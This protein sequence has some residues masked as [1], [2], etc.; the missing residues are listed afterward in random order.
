MLLDICY[1]L[2][3]TTSVCFGIS[4]C[5]YYFNRRLFNRLA[6]TLGWKSATIY[7]RVSTIMETYTKK[8]IQKLEDT[9]KKTEGDKSEEKNII[10]YN[11]KTQETTKSISMPLQ[12][13]LVFIKKKIDD[14]IYCK[15]IKESKNLHSFPFN[16]IKKPFI[17]VEIAYDDKKMEI[18]EHL[19]HFYL[20][21]NILLDSLFIQWYMKFWFNEDISDEYTLHIIDSNVQF[22]QL[23][24]TQS[25]LLTADGYEIL[26]GEE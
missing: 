1:Y 12:Q 5:T 18:Q 4:M 25:V 11:S 10:S 6:L 14:T 23:E 8:P 7:H 20:E 26:Q 9:K 15:R 16:I 17:Q 2:G 21:N 13:D 24:P 22:I 3:L 19:E